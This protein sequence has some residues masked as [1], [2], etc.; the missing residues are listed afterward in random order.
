MKRS[1]KYLEL[2]VYQATL[3][4]GRNLGGWPR[5]VWCTQAQRL[6]DLLVPTTDPAGLSAASACYA[7]ADL[8][9]EFGAFSASSMSSRLGPVTASKY[10]HKGSRF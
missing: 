2:D 6:H 8:Q 9:G 5:E 7:A 4:R 3:R 10:V 1:S